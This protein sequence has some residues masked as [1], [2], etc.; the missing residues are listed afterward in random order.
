MKK[1]VAFLL[2][3]A[4]FCTLT[5]CGGRPEPE[6][7]APA[8]EATEAP[9]TAAPTTAAPTTAATTAV[10]TTEAKTEA[11]TEA[12]TEA[13]TAEPE[14]TEEETELTLALPDERIN[15]PYAEDE[16]YNPK[17]YPDLAKRGDFSDKQCGEV[18]EGVSDIL[19]F[20]FYESGQ[21]IEYYYGPSVIQMLVTAEDGDTTIC[22]AD[23]M[24]GNELLDKVMKSAGYDEY[25]VNYYY[26]HGIWKYDDEEPAPVFI[27]LLIDGNFYDYYI[28]DG[29]LV[30]RETA[31]GTT[32]NPETN[33]FMSSVYKIGCYYGKYLACEKN[34]YD[35]FVYAPDY[36]V[37][38][39]DTVVITA[40]ISGTDC[41]YDFIV[42]KDTKF[43]DDCELEFFEDYKDGET[44]LEWYQRMIETNETGT[45]VVGVFDVRTTG[46]HIDY[47]C[48][49]YW[50]D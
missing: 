2:A 39:D 49:C 33:D 44:P 6:T 5:A 10:P 29:K 36:V 37:E 31:D 27:E 38:K 24:N 9:T 12:T 19:A 42:D 35:L 43:A 7:A 30:M 45:A 22:S 47:I 41:G 21:L 8:S 3:A 18:L 16:E 50:W 4:L 17:D 40:D 23:V 25:E 28:A 15:N 46:T 14:T 26:K 32:N 20:D 13:T 48:G 34:R 11:A 1:T